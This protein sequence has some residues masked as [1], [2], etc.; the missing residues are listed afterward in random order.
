MSIV[1]L[2][3]RIHAC[4]TRMGP[5]V[6]HPL[7]IRLKH[8]LCYTRGHTRNLRM[9]HDIISVRHQ[10]Y[11]VGDRPIDHV[12]MG[13]PGSNIGHSKMQLVPN[14]PIWKVRSRIARLALG[15]GTLPHPRV[16]SRIPQISR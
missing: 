16:L 2:W 6:A 8:K 3:T 14:V 4:E 5:I 1:L 11:R 10:G 15:D 7:G 13:V 9:H 12:T